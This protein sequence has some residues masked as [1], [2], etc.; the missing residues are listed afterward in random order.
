[1]I[2]NNPQVSTVQILRGKSILT[3][4][5]DGDQISSN[6]F[7]EKQLELE[8]LVPLNN[9]ISKN[10]FCTHKRKNSITNTEIL[11]RLYYLQSKN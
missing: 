10:D 1:M 6:Q 8:S 2:D 11:D 4:A 9:F 5:C 3:G 7:D